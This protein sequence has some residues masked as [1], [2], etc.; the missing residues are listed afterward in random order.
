[1]RPGWGAPEALSRQV[2][3][4][5]EIK[6]APGRWRFALR[7]TFLA[8][9]ALFSVALTMA[10]TLAVVG[11]TGG[12][13]ATT[14]PTRPWRERTVVLGVMYPLYVLS[15]WLGAVTGER[16][17]LLTIVLAGISLVTVLVYNAVVGDQPGPMF[18]ILGAAIASYLP[19]RGIPVL[20][21]VEV[22]AL[23]GGTA[24]LASILLQMARRD[25]SVQDAIRDADEAVTAYVQSPHGVG[26]P[27][28]RGRLR[29][30]AFASVFRASTV[31]EAAVGHTPHSR[32][33]ARANLRLRRLHAD[34]VRRVSQV[35]LHD[36]PIAVSRMEA[37]RY[38]GSP[39]F[40]Y[41]VRWGVSQRSLP[42][43]AARRF[44]AAVVLTCA[45][46]YGLHTGHPYWA[47]MTAALIMTVTADRLSLTHRALHRLAGTAVGVLLFF[48]LHALNPRGAWL[49]AVILVAV[50]AMQMVVVR[51]YALGAMLI[52]PM[53]LAMSTASNPYQPA[54]AIAGSRIIETAI[55]A[56]CSVIVIWASSR[57]TPV[58]LVRRQFR[59]ALRALERVL[60]LLADGEQST[61]RGFEARRDLS[62]EQLQ[63]AQVLQIAQTDLPLALGTWTE[64]EA[65]INEVS[66]TVLAA[67]WTVDPPSTLD[68]AEMARAL[69][70]L[71]AR[72]PPVS[73]ETVDAQQ[74]ARALHE[75]LRVGRAS[76]PPLVAP[77]GTV[78]G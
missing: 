12:F 65:A 22:N 57:G 5:T 18:L 51:N 17:W 10:P 63:C 61:D 24:C 9:V 42:W 30:R 20:K 14:A 26:D 16:P 78:T 52:T 31:L 39:S 49:L 36:A 70:R 19:T 48:G 45:V 38:L 13:L 56:A 46:S 75:V 59:R 35:R 6:P 67:C 69:Q 27:A 33:W 60:V 37:S 21:V 55:G 66:Y 34:L 64:L 7:A 8:A 77:V 41:L 43:L 4:F 40:R 2:L 29:D 15:V 3:A 44:T 58:V 50:F 72:L 32:R 25:T 47:V 71:L 73:R 23:A 68:A 53:A 74:V 54:G 62:F 76:P 1:M 11:L 28:E